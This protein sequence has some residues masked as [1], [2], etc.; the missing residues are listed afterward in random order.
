MFF[1]LAHERIFIR[2]HS[3]ESRS[4]TGPENVLAAVV[5]LRLSARK[6]DR[7]GQ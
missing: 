4:V 2:T 6:F 3:K 5:C 7:P 1:E